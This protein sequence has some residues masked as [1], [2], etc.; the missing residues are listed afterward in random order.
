MKRIKYYALSINPSYC[1]VDEIKGMTYEEVVKYVDSVEQGN[2]CF[3]VYEGYVDE[4]DSLVPDGNKYDF[5]TMFV[6]FH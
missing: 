5:D 1:D 3:S 4:C 6:W 2:R